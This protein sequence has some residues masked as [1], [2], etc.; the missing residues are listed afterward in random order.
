[1][2][3]ALNIKANLSLRHVN[4]CACFAVLNC[5]LLQVFP[6]L[7]IKVIS[8][9]K[10]LGLMGQDFPIPQSGHQLHE[11]SW[12]LSMP[13]SRKSILSRTST[14]S[15]KS[16]LYLPLPKVTQS[17]TLITD[18]TICIVISHS[19]GTF[20]PLAVANLLQAVTKV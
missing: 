2:F 5:Q 19:G 9:N 1:M 14:I 13:P 20:G 16:I 3:P 17:E 12:N 15:R 7:N 8:S 11:G 18:S 4:L 10:L 6:A